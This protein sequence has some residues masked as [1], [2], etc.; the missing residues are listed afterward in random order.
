MNGRTALTVRPHEVETGDI[1]IGLT[2]VV[3][4]VSYVNGR[5]WYE[6][7]EGDVICTRSPWGSVQV[8]RETA[9]A[10]DT[11]AHGI[12]RPVINPVLTLVAR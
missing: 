9:D 8:W 2:R 1:L 5:W 10:D 11:P 7:A 3:A 6:A 4:E 12:A